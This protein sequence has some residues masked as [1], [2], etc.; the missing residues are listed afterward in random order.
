MLSRNVIWVAAAW[1]AMLFPSSVSAGEFHPDETTRLEEVIVEAPD[2]KETFAFLELENLTLRAAS[3]AAH[4]TAGLL[5]DVP[6][7]SLY[8]AGGVSSLPSIRGL[9]D[10]RLRV[11]VDGMDLVASCPNHMNPAL[12]YIDPASVDSV[13][14]YAGI[15]PVS[16]GGDSIGGSIVVDSARPRFVERGE[17]VKV[18]GHT[19]VGYRGSGDQLDGDLS[20]N[21]A[22]ERLHL[23][24]AGSAAG[25]DD[26]ESAEDFKRTT[27]TGRN[28]HTLSLD[29]VGS[30]AYRAQ[31]HALGVAWRLG[32]QVLEVRMAYQDVPYQLY[33]NQRMDMLDNT[34]YRPSLRYFGEFEWGQL[35]ARAYY[36][37]VEHEMDFGDDKRFWYGA[38]SGVGSPCSPVSAACAEGMPMQTEGDT[39][40]ASFGADV[41][42]V[43]GSV[44]RMGTQTQ[45]YRLDD[46]WPASGGMMWPNPF[47]HIHNGRRDRMAWYGEWEKRFGGSWTTLSGIR[48]EYVRM[49]SGDVTG[50][51]PSG[52]GNQGRDAALFNASDREKND[53]N[54]DAAALARW[55]VNDALDIELG[56]AHKTRSP[57][58]YER[59][60]WST[61]SMPAVMVNWFGDGNGYVGNLDLEPEKA[62]TVSATLGLHSA[63][64]KQELKVTPHYTHVR[65]YIDAVQWNAAANSAATSLV[66]N[67][68]SVLKFV[69]QSARLYGVDV[70][71]AAPLAATRSGE[72]GLRGLL[73]YTRGENTDTG[74]GL[75]N[76]MPVNGG[77]TLTHSLGGWQHEIETVWVGEKSE[78]SDMRNEIET[79]GYGLMHLRGSYSWQR[80]R[81][82]FGVENLLDKQYAHPLGGAY[83]GQG[84]SMVL[85]PTDGTLSWGT[86]VPG[87]GRFFYARVRVEF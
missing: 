64:R 15:A 84:A 50:Y 73:S 42:L 87:P 17:G 22:T 78:V 45:F 28:G 51:N 77:L 43:D 58:L 57:N 75:Y 34:E 30:T 61:W 32:D 62:D 24:Y 3:A 67:Q 41:D 86:P 76:I 26:Y 46:R 5:A 83:V 21:L 85:N 74:D 27:A 29:T 65:D 81:V 39:V 13:K 70:S 2:L 31:N 37:K 72:F 47:I 12:S 33:P 48:Y 4:D 10:D 68:F 53:D 60:A 54:L 35:E 71:A 69:N 38:L 44:L 8:G 11:K 63:D 55:T 16:L 80:T 19:S 49:D 18:E 59:Y 36:Q 82:D 23:S 7:V 14:V 40:G 25:S 66:R 1:F 52:A 79:G 56:Y 9:A 6:G 20:L